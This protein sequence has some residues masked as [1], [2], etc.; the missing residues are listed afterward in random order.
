MIGFEFVLRRRLVEDLLDPGAGGGPPFQPGGGSTPPRTRGSAGFDRGKLPRRSVGMARTL[1]RSPRR[2]P[3]PRMSSESN[4]DVVRLNVNKLDFGIPGKEV[5]LGIPFRIDSPPLSPPSG[6]AGAPERGSPPVPEPERAGAG[7]R[8]GDDGG[9]RRHQGFGIPEVVL[10]P[11]QQEGFP[12]GRDIVR[13]GGRWRPREGGNQC[14][15]HAG[16]ARRPGMGKEAWEDSPRSR[17]RGRIYP[18]RS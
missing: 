7:C 14:S 2:R 4:L 18:A 8:R 11:A 9:E 1:W 6:C 3:G 10:L 15:Q 12:R 17:I 13:Q 16:G 5:L